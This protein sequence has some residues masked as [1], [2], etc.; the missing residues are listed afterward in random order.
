MTCRISRLLLQTLMLQLCLRDISEIVDDRL[1]DPAPSVRADELRCVCEVDR[2]YPNERHSDES[3]ELIRA[4]EVMDRSYA[5]P[6]AGDL[7]SQHVVK[8]V[9]S[10]HVVKEVIGSVVDRPRVVT[11]HD[12]QKPLTLSRCSRANDGT[13]HLDI[14]LMATAD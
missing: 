6:L 12:E 7:H 1:H 10:Q 8:E 3:K 5:T 4:R 14:R 13:I 2:I 11:V 9:H